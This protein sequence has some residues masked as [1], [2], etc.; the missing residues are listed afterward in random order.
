MH[1]FCFFCFFFSCKST[2]FIIN[3][4]FSD[5]KATAT[6]RMWNESCTDRAMRLE[7]LELLIYNS[8]E[9]SSKISTEDRWLLGHA[10]EY[11]FCRFVWRLP[12]KAAWASCDNYR[13]HPT[14]S[15]SDRWAYQLSC[16]ALVTRRSTWKGYSFWWLLAYSLLVFY[17]EK[18]QR[19]WNIRASSWFDWLQSKSLLIDT[20]IWHNERTI[21]IGN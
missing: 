16:G 19:W 18:R 2:Y 15:R 4:K 3:S 17:A 11:N 12:S 7:Q 6:E 14:V 20:P 8:S 10:G 1:F 21:G 9:G 5:H 13:T